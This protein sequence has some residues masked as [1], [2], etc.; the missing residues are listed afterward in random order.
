M[1]RLNL[2]LRPTIFVLALL[3]LSLLMLGNSQCADASAEDLIN[4]I[5]QPAQI[6]TSTLEIQQQLELTVEEMINLGH[7]APTMYF[8]GGP[9][10]NILCYTF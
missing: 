7:L 1:K 9:A 10:G 6:T 2:H 8:I 3:L 4:T 5:P